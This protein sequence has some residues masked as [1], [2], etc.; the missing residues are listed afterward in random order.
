MVRVYFPPDA[1]STVCVMAHCLRSKNYVNLIVGSKADT[2]SYLSIEETERHC[3][4]GATVWKKFS[5]EDGVNPDVTLVGIGVETT[6]EVVIAAK[7]LRKEGVRVRL[8]NIVDL[9]ILGEFGSHPHALSNDDF[10]ALFGV[11]TP[12]VINYHGYPA[13]VKSLLFARNHAITRKR[14]E[15]LGYIEEGTTT[16]PWSMLRMNKAGRFDV[17]EKAI[18]LI[19]ATKPE[20]AIA[21]KGHELRA[22]FMHQNQVYEK[23]ANDHGVDSPDLNAGTVMFEA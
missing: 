18:A 21:V 5:T 22:W 12:V 23:Y 11:D 20:S 1:A 9:M 16:T 13:Q 2:S 19:T 3:I 15:I 14:F 4:A 8:V 6:A 17:A 7:I 10:D